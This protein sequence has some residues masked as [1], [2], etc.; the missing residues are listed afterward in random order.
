MV[1]DSLDLPSPLITTT[2]TEPTYPTQLSP[3]PS[4]LQGSP[5]APP[6]PSSD[7]SVLPLTFENLHKLHQP[8]RDTMADLHTPQRSSEA[9]RTTSAIS[10]QAGYVREILE[11]N[12]LSIDDAR[13]RKAFHEGIDKAKKLISEPRHSEPSKQLLDDI[14][15]VRMDYADRNETTFTN[16]FFGVFQ[17]KSRHVKQQQQQQQAQ[18]GHDQGDSDQEGNLHVPIGWAARDWADDGLDENDNRIWQGGSVPRISPMDENQ[19][20]I[21]KDLP[22]LS[23]PQPDLLYGTSI[24][25]H[26]THEE[27]AVIA[28]FK[29]IT[30]ISLGL[31]CP[32]FGVEVKTKGDFE[33]GVNQGC[34]VGAGM[35]ACHRKLKALAALKA[36]IHD[37]AG[38]N[39]TAANTHAIPNHPDS[40]NASKAHPTTEVAGGKAKAKAKADSNTSKA[41]FSTQAFTMILM[42]KL[43]QINVHWVEVGEGEGEGEQA[44]TYHMHSIGS[45]ALNDQDNLKACRA[46]ANNILAWGL[47]ERDKEI[48]LLLNQIQDRYKALKAAKAKAKGK[49]TSVDKSPESKKRRVDDIDDGD[50]EIME[51]MQSFNKEY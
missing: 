23:N 10:K 12:R 3:S 24:K 22:K 4:S 51:E 30:Q 37:T 45:Y 50:F 5:S 46:A 49:A 36:K 13:A 42:P 18:G 33:E 41:D 6:T 20:A 25:K 47:G 15:Q 34:T 28:L 31:A 16:K 43:A 29:D 21:L 48:K 1:E 9:S 35:V 40:T 26:Y 8:R 44:L 7:S 39:P 38:T 11:L 14:D 19:K 2:C 32:F 17:S 27:R